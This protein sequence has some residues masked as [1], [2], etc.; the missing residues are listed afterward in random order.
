[1]QQGSEGMPEGSHGMQQGG[2]EPSYKEGEGSSASAE[3]MSAPD[4]NVSG[5]VRFTEGADGKV[6]VEAELRGLTPGAHG[7]HIHETGE[8]TPP[9]FE[10]AGGHFAGDV[11]Q[12]GAPDARRHHAGD[13]GNVR[14]SS[15]GTARLRIESDDISLGEGPTSIIGKAFIVHAGRDDMRSQPSGN[16]GGR[17][18]CGIIRAAS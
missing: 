1:M 7:V 18:A 5:T 6:R 3:L 14:A 16:S 15:N 11:D 17:V 12:H 10:S 13:F 8:C 9:S 4:S 2:Q